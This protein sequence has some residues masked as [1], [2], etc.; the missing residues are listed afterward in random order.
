MIVFV[1][2][3]ALLAIPPVRRYA[4]FDFRSGLDWGL[5]VVGSLL[6]ED[7]AEHVIKFFSH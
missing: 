4:D 1:G 7:V 5:L 2:A 3:L 6:A